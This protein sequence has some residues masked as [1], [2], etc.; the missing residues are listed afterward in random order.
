MSDEWY[1]Q[2][3]KFSWKPTSQE[4]RNISYKSSSASG[5]K[6]IYY[7]K[8]YSNEID[9]HIKYRIIKDV[10]NVEY[11]SLRILNI[12]SDTDLI[13]ALV[14]NDLV[15]KY[16]AYSPEIKDMLRMEKSEEKECT[17]LNQC[18]IP[19]ILIW[20][21]MLTRQPKISSPVYD[22]Q[23]VF[24]LYTKTP[25]PDCRIE[26][27]SMDF[28]NSSYC[29]VKYRIFQSYGHD[30]PE[31]TMMLYNTEDGVRVKI[32]KGVMEQVQSEEDMLRILGNNILYH[33]W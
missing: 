8:G 22:N 5:S 25:S 3:K 30:P 21:D 32:A 27:D 6:G 17:D 2:I 23:G 20:I 19:S 9:Y 7:K 1:E 11:L 26:I 18:E 13:N 4:I 16:H 24:C 14:Q 29:H 31:K 33:R 15:R 28:T 10:L 12:A